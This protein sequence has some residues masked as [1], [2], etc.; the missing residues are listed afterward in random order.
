MAH[1][2]FFSESTIMDSE[3][4]QLQGVWVHDPENPDDSIQQYR[5]GKDNRSDDVEVHASEQFFAGRELPVYDFGEHTQDDSSYSVLV[6]SGD[7]YHEKMQTLKSFV[8]SRRIVIVRDNRG[9]HSRGVILSVSK[10]DQ[11][12]GTEAT[13]TVHRTDTTVAEEF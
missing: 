10:T 9:R 6:A 4:L 2:E 1:F 5:F 13:F 3:P 8:K 12:I 11:P 7:D